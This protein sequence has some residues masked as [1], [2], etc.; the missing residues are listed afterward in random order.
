MSTKRGSEQTQHIVYAYNSSY[1][2]AEAEGSQV[3]GQHG[4]Q[5]KTLDQNK[6]IKGAEGV[7]D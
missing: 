5:R 1:S 7:R 3:G 4:L 6:I 2:E